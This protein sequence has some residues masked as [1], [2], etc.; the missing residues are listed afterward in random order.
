MSDPPTVLDDDDEVRS[1]QSLARIRTDRAMS[2]RRIRV[3]GLVQGVGFRPHVWRIA[4]AE[5]LSGSVRNDGEGVEIEAWGDAGALSRFTR[6]IG[7][8]APPLARIDAIESE[9][10]DGAAPEG[11]FRIAESARGGIATGIVPDAATCPAC[12]ADILDPA[13]RRYRYAFTNCTHCGPRLSIIRAIP[14]DRATTSMSAFDMCP[15]CQGEYEDPGDRRF[16]AQPNT[17]PDCG[18]RLW[19]EDRDGAVTAG[20]AIDETARLLREGNIVAVKGIGGFHLACD[21]MSED[22][23]VELRRRKQ[24]YGK[25]FAV[26]ARDTAMIARF[27][28]FGEEEVRWLE[29][30]TAPIVLVEAAGE[31]LAAGVAPGHDLIGAMLPYTPLHHL[32]MR[33][34]E[35]PIVL[36]SGNRSDEPQ[37]IDNDEARRRLAAI[38]DHWLMHDRAIVN[39]LDDSVMRIDRTGPVVLRRARGFAP[40]PLRLDPTFADRP[41]VLAMGGELKATFCLLRNGEAVLSPHLG[42]LEEAAT[43]ADYRASLALYRQIFGFDPEII[44][45]DRHPDYL[46]SQWGA[47]LA[48]ESGARLVP[49]QHH[50]AHLAACLAEHGVPAGEGRSLGII[51]DGLGLG[52]D[53]T[54]WGG[55]L[56]LGG[57]DGFERAGHFLP[58]AMPG[59]AQAVREPWR[60]ACAHLRAAFGE[61]MAA[62]I[63]GTDFAAFLAGKPLAVVERMIATGLNSPLASSAGRLFDAVAAV[64]GVCRERQSYEGQAAMEMEALARPFMSEE[65]AYPFERLQG[66]RL[67]LAWAPLWRALLADLAAGSPPGRMAARFHLGLAAAVA[68]A[69]VAIAENAGVQRIVL[70]GGVMQNRLLSESLSHRLSAA[71][72]D[73]LT[74]RHIPANDGGLAV[75]QA[76]IAALA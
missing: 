35:G 9:G 60:N 25:P 51:L 14:Y 26:M 4:R 37:V 18:P 38:A 5:G 68:D 69:A 65:T 8:E 66:A 41:P 62:V 21:A 49:V 64:M 2:G 11:P 16:H 39:R 31:P 67:M 57:C 53:G 3:R 48:A 7:A 47:K 33:A 70:S 73:V 59:G 28:R 54:I 61:D 1:L 45:V 30:A 23:V 63:A 72:Y 29:D 55:E 27:A 42:D 12:L 32:L 6:R 34:L 13:N 22:A 19:L 52:D 71:G 40:A 17:C 75:G 46:S 50:H 36:T 43:H 44:A 76:V 20:D 58:V 24:R 10:L 56:L 15:A 74:H